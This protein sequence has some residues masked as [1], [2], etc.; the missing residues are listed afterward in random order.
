MR[1]IEGAKEIVRGK[2]YT[3]IVVSLFFHAI[4]YEY[5]F[6][7]HS[8]CNIYNVSLI[9]SSYC[10]FVL[11]AKN[12]KKVNYELCHYMG[13]EW[14]ASY[15]VENDK[16]QLSRTQHNSMETYTCTYLGIAGKKIHND[17]HIKY[18]VVKIQIKNALKFIYDMDVAMMMYMKTCRTNG[19]IVKMARF[20]DIYLNVWFHMI[21]SHL[22]FCCHWI[23]LSRYFVTP[24]IDFFCDQIKYSISSRACVYFLHSTFR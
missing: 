10:A 4:Q 11:K 15:P 3:S 16:R 8:M 21:I 1:R 17:D 23:S 12:R 5:F 7:A 6:F 14:G 13:T 9:H 2:L 20:I 18:T 24:K 22:V 19:Q